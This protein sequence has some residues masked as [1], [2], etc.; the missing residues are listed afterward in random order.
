M[1]YGSG[2]CPAV[3]NKSAMKQMVL[4]LYLICGIIIFSVCP[5]AKKIPKPSSESRKKSLSGRLIKFS[6]PL[7]FMGK[8][9]SVKKDAFSRGLG[10]VAQFQWLSFVQNFA[11]LKATS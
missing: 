1:T 6:C 8:I 7:S 11:F 5:S 10:W 2:I 9:F 4:S 3:G